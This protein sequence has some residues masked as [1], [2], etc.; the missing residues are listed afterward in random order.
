MAVWFSY[1]RLTI[2]A[3]RR[4]RKIC[5]NHVNLL[6]GFNLYTMVLISMSSSCHKSSDWLKVV[7]VL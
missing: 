5:F 7:I 3:K 2:I 4:N 6:Q 1:D